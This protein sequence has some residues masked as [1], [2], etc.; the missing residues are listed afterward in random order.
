ME[1]LNSLDVK[2]YDRLDKKIEDPHYTG[3]TP[4]GT[5]IEYGGEF[6]VIAQNV[7]Q[8]EKL[9]HLVGETSEGVKTVDYRSLFVMTM[10]ALQE[11]DARCKQL[12][13]EVKELKKA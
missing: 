13:S 7:E 11:L 9:K 5:K 6:G 12:E 8:N 2:V 3:P 4:E 1:A 10:G